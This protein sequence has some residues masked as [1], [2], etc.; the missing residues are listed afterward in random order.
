MQGFNDRRPVAAVRPIELRSKA[1]L[2]EHMVS[3]HGQRMSYDS[4]SELREAHQDT[5][6]DQFAII[7]VPHAHGPN[8][9]AVNPLGG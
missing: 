9:A 8:A 1:A 7:S 2:E 4:H 5:H 3:H 6:A